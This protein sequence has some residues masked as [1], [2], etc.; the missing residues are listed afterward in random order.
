MRTKL[1][2][3]VLACLAIFGPSRPGLAVS[4]T[5]IP[6]DLF[7]HLQKQG[8]T[9][10]S[11]GVMQRGLGG[12]RVE[13]LGFGVDG[14][15]FQLREMKAHLVDL[16]K[17][18]AQHP[19]R[20]LRIAIRSHRAQILRIE[21]ALRKAK[22]V[23]G[24]EISAEGLIA[25]GP[26]CSASYDASALAFPIAQGASSKAAAYFNNTC[27]YTGE[28]YA[29]SKSKATA[30]DS[31]VTITT[32]SDPAL[33]TPRI[34]GNV[35]AD[36]ATSVNG[37]SQC[38]SYAYASVLNYDLEITYAQSDQNLSCVA[39]LPS[40]WTK[41]DVGTVGLA[42]G[43]SYNSGVFRLTAGGTDLA[44]T[45]DA[46]HF[47]HQTLSGD[48]TIVA[49]VAALLKPAGATRTLGGVTFR[50]DLT[51]GSA[52]ATMTIT[53]EGEAQ[54]RRRATAGGATTSD[55]AATTFAPQW[56]RIDRSGNTFTAYLSANG[57]TWT[58]V[59]TPQTI[60]MSTSV[61]VGLVALRNG[62]GAP[63]GAAR[64]E[65]VTVSPPA[66]PALNYFAVN[67][68]R[69]LDTRNTTI[70][71][72]NQPRT[73]T[74]AGNCGIP[75]TARAVS[76]N[77]TAISPTDSGKIAL[78]PGDLTAIASSL[79][80]APATSPRSN[81]AIIQLATNAAGTMGINAVVAGSPGQVHLTLDVDGYFSK[82]TTAASGAVGPLGFQTLP[83]CR[84]ANTTS[85]TALSAGT[86]RTFTAQGVCGIPVGAAVASLHVGATTPT[87]G[88]QITLFPSSITAPGTSSVSFP[89]GI[90]NLRNGARVRLS[91]T[92]PDL[93]ALFSST[94]PGAS[95]HAHFDVNGYYKSDAPLKYRPITPCRVVDTASSPLVTDIVRTFQV[96]G[97]CGVP[98]GAKA[99]V[100]RLVVSGPTSA[101]DLSVYP[102][103][104]SQAPGSTV[105]FDANEPG[106]SMGTTVPLSTLTQ[107]LAA[108]PG[109][110]TAG[111][112]VSLSVDVFGYFQ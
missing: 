85:S 39:S 48:G 28:V 55:S 83:I 6:A 56:L 29:H 79:N 50:N 86:T 98:V 11:S 103:N 88:G 108:S 23:D 2:L 73:L 19:S 78:Y 87:S 107:D 77:V 94:T 101:G 102:S 5:P 100:V 67:P 80:F 59:G 49:N 40:P 53:S 63:T 24:L 8:W 34:G 111:G 65:S 10:V 89:A 81:S 44:G 7:D 12:N 26:G 14:L 13:T 37:V 110:M 96:Q 43:A 52:H 57:V 4:S 18:Y 35:N 68:C 69:L 82:D 1:V 64:F 95:T 15:R 21:E 33:D 58:L 54:F 104:L 90:T 112:T 20:Q 75:S 99:V 72:H 97:N 61:Q 41:T 16:R 32:L 71:T 25:Q 109:Q 51:A 106:L 74:V 70:L 42:G 3:C 91:S 92:T 17:D 76:V 46:F 45:A 66:A 47:V 105:K 62:S 31:S 27:G 9:E 36:A 60:T 84:I 22:P 30:A 38:D 93:A